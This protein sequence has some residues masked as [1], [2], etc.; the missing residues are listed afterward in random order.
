MT[1]GLSTLGNFRF[2]LTFKDGTTSHTI[3]Q[4]LSL[5]EIGFKSGP[6]QP[7]WDGPP[8][9]LI[10]FGRNYVNRAT[11]REVPISPIVAPTFSLSPGRDTSL[12]DAARIF[13]Y[14]TKG[15]VEIVNGTF[16][17]YTNTQFKQKAA[18]AAL[19]GQP[20]P[21][22]YFNRS[23]DEI[24]WAYA[25]K[26]LFWLRTGG[27][28]R[29]VTVLETTQMAARL[30]QKLVARLMPS[31][32]T[33]TN[34]LI[35]FSFNSKNDKYDLDPQM[36]VSAIRIARPPFWGIGHPDVALSDQQDLQ[37]LLTIYACCYAGA[38]EYEPNPVLADGGRYTVSLPCYE[39][40]YLPR[41]SSGVMPQLFLTDYG[42]SGAVLLLAGLIDD[43]A[44]A[45]KLIIPEN[46]SPM[47]GG[48]D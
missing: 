37:T 26:I 17:G 43:L 32:N 1:T 31:G 38:A 29:L 12:F 36:V 20:L 28:D 11:A 24:I 42:N 6:D 22:L 48:L 45:I 21:N 2:N 35:T 18:D 47:T 3:Q 8:V 30:N 27:S 41:P 40:T 19:P 10:P 9:D 46:V 15:I 16:Y 39:A 7:S 34:P 5:F 25:W 44:A 23:E 33:Y 14:Y 13:E 4:F